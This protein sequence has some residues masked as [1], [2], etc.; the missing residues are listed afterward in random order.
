MIDTIKG[1]Y[2]GPADQVMLLDFAS[3]YP[4]LMLSHAICPSRYVRQGE[5]SEVAAS[6]EEGVVVV[7]HHVSATKTVKLARP[8]LKGDVPP[9]SLI[10]EKLLYERAKVRKLLK[11]ET[12]PGQR[13]VLDKRQLARK[14]ACN[15]TYGILGATKGYLP[16]PD[17]AAVTTYQG[18]EALQYTQD[19]AVGKYGCKVIGGT[20]KVNHC[21]LMAQQLTYS[22]LPFQATRTVYF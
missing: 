17:L 20:L 12:D 2:G 13:I 1:F 4:N 16:L 5:A 15:S 22:C 14:V 9:L 7:E 8:S 18:R 3:L 6:L 19:I 21:L 11:A 10:L